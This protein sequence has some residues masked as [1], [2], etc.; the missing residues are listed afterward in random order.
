MNNFI[1]LIKSFLSGLSKKERLLLYAACFVL[2]LLFFDKVIYS[3][4]SQRINGIEDKI[5]MQKELIHKNLL[6][7]KHE[8]QIIAERK[9][10]QDFF[11]QEGLSHEEKVAEFL[12]EVERLA[13]S[14]QITLINIDPVEIEEEN[15][16]SKYKLTIEGRAKMEN[17]LRFIYTLDNT[18]KPIRT[19]SCEITPQK[20]SEYL[21]QAIIEIEKLIIVSDEK[22]D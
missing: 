3:P 15:E 18:D 19:I 16:F 12:G 17:I 8:G 22:D 10:Y 2:L 4:I 7:L 9:K 5:S 21:V 1:N 13:K 11:S 20:R 14:S 6:I